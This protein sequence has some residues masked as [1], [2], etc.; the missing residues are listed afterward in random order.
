MRERQESILSVQC[1]LRLHCASSLTHHFLYQSSAS[2][3]AAF[4]K[5]PCFNFSHFS[6]PPLRSPPK[7]Y[8]WCSCWIRQP[9]NRLHLAKHLQ[10]QTSEFPYSQRKNSNNCEA[11]YK[12]TSKVPIYTAYTVKNNDYTQVNRAMFFFLLLLAVY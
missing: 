7:L 2:E 12:R 3:L 6:P 9:A 8:R 5:T 11:F 10:N 4:H 1:T